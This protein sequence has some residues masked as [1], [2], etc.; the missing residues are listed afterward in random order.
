MRRDYNAGGKAVVGIIG[1]GNFSS[2]VLLPAL[3]K[4]NACIAY[5]ADINVVAAQHAARKFS[6]DRATADYKIILNDPAVNTVF[7]VV[8]HHLHAKFV[9]EAIEAGKNVYVEKPLAVNETELKKVTEA[10]NS[11]PDRLIMVG[12]NRRFSPHIKKIK[13]L[14]TGRQEPLCMSMTVNAGFIPADHWTQD[15][16]RGAG[17][18]IGEACHFIDLL[19]HLADST[20][21]TVSCMMVE[22]HTSVCDDKVSI[23][24]KFLDGSIGTVNYFANG[25]KRYPKETLE[26]FSDGRVIRLDNFRTTTSYGF[27]GFG[28]FRT[29]RQDKGHINQIKSFIEL[30]QK[31]DRPLIAF[32]QLVNATKVSFTAVLSAK[33]NR[34]IT[35]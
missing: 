15:P 12:F 8:S 26:V 7:I 29:I 4:T 9:C 5:I 30:I 19:S 2:S 22:G 13:E 32:D 31:G 33:E 3:S 16:E 35:L 10:V 24:L 25:S 14:L 17:R 1:A 20:V 11:N 23:I 27:R 18:I 6:A 28:K 34:T 21:K